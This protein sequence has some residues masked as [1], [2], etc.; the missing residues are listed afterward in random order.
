MPVPP[1]RPH[2][3]CWSTGNPSPLQVET[4]LQLFAAH[5]PTQF[6]QKQD[7]PAERPLRQGRLRSWPA[8]A[9]LRPRVVLSQP[10]L[11]QLGA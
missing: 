9:H 7:W 3:A 5:C 2:A 11:L 8:R 1:P 10:A 6:V 4:T